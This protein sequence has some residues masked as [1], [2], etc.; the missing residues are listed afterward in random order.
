MDLAEALGEAGAG[1]VE[2]SFALF[3]ETLDSEWIA[4]ALQATGTA[5][6]RRR[7]LPAEYVVWL[8]I[9]MALLRDRSIQEVVRHG[10]IVSG[11]NFRITC[12]APC[13]QR[14]RCTWYAPAAPGAPLPPHG[15]GFIAATSRNRAGYSTAER[16]R[17]TRTTPSSSG[18]RSASSAT[19]RNSPSS[20]RNRTPPF[21]RLISPG[22]IVWVPPP[23]I[24]TGE[25]P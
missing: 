8:V 4:Q 19:G 22:R 7:K 2:A 15:H 12:I 20:S 6:V 9:G 21:A 1:R 23:T 14:I 13:A 24:A 18:W 16:A 25:A 3:A 10:R 17:L 11:F 5:S